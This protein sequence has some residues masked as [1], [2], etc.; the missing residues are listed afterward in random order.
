M[1]LSEADRKLTPQ[2]RY[3]LRNVEKYRIYSRD[4]QRDLRTIAMYILGDECVRCG[5][6][7]ERALQLDHKIAIGAKRPPKMHT[8]YR[9]VIVSQNK[10]QLLCANCNWIK[11]VEN[12][13]HSS[14]L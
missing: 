8:I 14:K 5:F 13:E 7:D 4:Y 1:N 10:Y 3:Y 11:R 6:D 12:G 2:R 9:D